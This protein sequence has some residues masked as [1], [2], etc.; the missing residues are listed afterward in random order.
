ME[1]KLYSTAAGIQTRTWTGR[2]HVWVINGW[3]WASNQDEAT[4]KWAKLV[5]KDRPDD[6]WS[7][8]TMRVDLVP[9]ATRRTE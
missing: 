1:E 4:G 2:L 9:E 7:I 6:S 8:S 3:V 5:D